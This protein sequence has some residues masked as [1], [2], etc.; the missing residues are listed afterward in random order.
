MP[1]KRGGT[2]KGGAPP[3]VDEPP[4]PAEPIIESGTFYYESGALYEGEFT[5]AFDS[6]TFYIPPPEAVS[7]DAAATTGKGKDGKGAKK[8]VVEEEVL[9]PEEPPVRMRHGRGKYVDG[10]YIY[11]GEFAFD[12]FQG[13]GTFTFGSGSKYEGTWDQGLFKGLGKYTWA[14]GTMYEGAW[15]N[16]EMHGDGMYKDINGHRWGGEFQHNTGPG[17]VNQL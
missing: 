15:V 17:L 6:G 10:A 8:G 2:P 9:E 5:M 13:Q 16:N 14:N 3:P 11:E 12:V 7:P 4:P 1:P